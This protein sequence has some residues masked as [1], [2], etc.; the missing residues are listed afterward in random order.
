[1]GLAGRQAGRQAFDI[2]SIAFPPRFGIL[3]EVYSVRECAFNG[4][5]DMQACKQVNFI[6]GKCWRN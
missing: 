3:V 6:F 1:M 2:D 5:V 4:G